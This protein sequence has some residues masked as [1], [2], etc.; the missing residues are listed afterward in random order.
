M[1]IR[2]PKPLAEASFDLTPM[3]DIVLLL[4]IFFMFTSHFAKSQLSPMDLPKEKGEP[5]TSEKDGA[6]FIIDMDREGTMKT[7]GQTVT[8]ERLTELLKVDLANKKIK[9]GVIVRAERTCPSLHLNRLAGTL[10]AL[11]VRDWKLA[12]ANDGGGSSPGS[13]G[14]SVP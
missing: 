11:G 4:I 7:L 2:T 1:R 12:T 6:A 5:P 9:I 14:G 3:I 10:M 8:L 13:S